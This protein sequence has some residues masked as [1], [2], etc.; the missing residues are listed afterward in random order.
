[1]SA[2]ELLAR[3]RLLVSR[4]QTLAGSFES[5]RFG[6]K[7]LREAAVLE[8]RCNAA[9]H[10]TRCATFV[11]EIGD[12]QTQIRICLQWLDP[13]QELPQMRSLWLLS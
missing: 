11:G 4:M 3:V 5:G 2:T 8:K 9:C 7:L 6:K 12:V 10:F 13:V 1:M